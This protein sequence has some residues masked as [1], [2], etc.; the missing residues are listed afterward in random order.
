MAFS[1]AKFWGENE[2]G[3]SPGG[4]AYAGAKARFSIV[5]ID[6][7]AKAVRFHIGIKSYAAPVC[8]ASIRGRALAFSVFSTSSTRASP[9]S[10]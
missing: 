4:M 7:T 6:R 3:F 9:R 5:R 1:H 2:T 8:T 10:V